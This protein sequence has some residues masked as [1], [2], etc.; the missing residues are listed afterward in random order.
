MP[1]VRD[2]DA[3]YEDG[4][5]YARIKDAPYDIGYTTPQLNF[6]VVCDEGYE[7]VPVITDNKVD[8]ITHLDATKDGYNKFSDIFNQVI[9]DRE[10]LQANVRDL[11]A[12]R[13]EVTLSEVLAVHPLQ[14]GLSELLGYLVLA[15]HE[16][17]EA[18]DNRAL[19]RILFERDGQ[20]LMAICN[21]VVF[22]RK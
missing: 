16:E 14:Q 5:F 9:V 15:S 2:V 19:E 6:S 22:R 3:Y 1:S 18:F 21:R 20:K 10:Q 13:P 12:E 8:F 17:V 11:L 4:V 7:F